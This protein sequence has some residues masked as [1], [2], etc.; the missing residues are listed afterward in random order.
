[1]QNEDMIH[2]KLFNKDIDIGLC[3][4][5]GAVLCQT[6]Q[7]SS[8]PELNGYAREEIKSACDSCKYSD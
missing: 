6:L 5:V 7:F 1:M 2:C 8:V 4:E 3:S